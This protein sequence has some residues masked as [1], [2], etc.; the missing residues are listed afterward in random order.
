MKYI[1]AKFS[2]NKKSVHEQTVDGVLFAFFEGYASTFGNIDLTDEIVMRGAFKRSLESGKVIKMLWQHGFQDIIGQFPELKEDDKGLFVR[3]RINLGTEK[4]R[5]AIALL[6]A[7]DIDSMSIGYKI[8]EESFHRDLDVRLLKELELFEIS[9]V[10]EPANELARVTSVKGQVPQ[11]DLPILRDSEY[12]YDEQNMEKRVKD[13]KDEAYLWK[14]DDDNHRLLWADVVKGKLYIIPEA[15]DK[16]VEDLKKFEEYGMTKADVYA[17]REQLSKQYYKNVNEIE[18]WRVKAIEEIET[19]GDVETWLR[20][21]KEFSNKEAKRFISMCKSVFSRDRDDVES[22]GDQ[23]EC[24]AADDLGK[25]EE[26][27]NSIRSIKQSLLRGTENGR[28]NESSKGHGSSER[29]SRHS[30]GSEVQS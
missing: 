10:T 13:S 14:G 17:V 16:V 28:R 29:T 1:E 26:L 22:T 11:I 20:S 2:I 3:G 4:G 21:V 5:E 15:V 18:P 25:I 24:D 6:R 30:S 7:G 8:I 27:I 12:K 9:L 23:K 19:A